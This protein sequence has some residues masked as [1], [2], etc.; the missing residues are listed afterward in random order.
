MRW[1]EMAARQKKR[2]FFFFLLLFIFYCVLWSIRDE[3]G[4]KM[5]IYLPKGAI[6]RKGAP[7]NGLIMADISSFSS[8]SQWS[9][10]YFILNNSLKDIFISKFFVTLNRESGRLRNKIN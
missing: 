9:P 3:K 1:K 7:N 4:E 10:F 2:N 5:L 6:K 8:R